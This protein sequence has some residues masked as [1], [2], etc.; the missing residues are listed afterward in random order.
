MSRRCRGEGTCLPQLYQVRLAILLPLR[1]S[2][3]GL[4]TVAVEAPPWDIG[5]MRDPVTTIGLAY[6][7]YGNRP[8]GIRQADRMQHVYVIDQTGTGKST[9]IAM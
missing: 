7:R 2:Q 3:S 9:L 8:F 6:D 4:R 1:L 5:G